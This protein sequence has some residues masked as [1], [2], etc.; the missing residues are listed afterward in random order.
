MTTFTLHGYTIANAVLLET[1]N[2]YKLRAWIQDQMI[3][4]LRED[5][6]SPAPFLERFNCALKKSEFSGMD[7]SFFGIETGGPAEE[8]DTELIIV[9]DSESS[10][11]YNITIN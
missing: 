10:K 1:P 8:F 3:K 5:E 7:A 11:H 6:G 4:C 9:V 2:P